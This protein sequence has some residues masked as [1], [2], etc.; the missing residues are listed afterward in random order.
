MK[1]P[2]ALRAAMTENNRYLRDNPDQLH[3]F[4]DAGRLIATRAAGAVGSKG[5]SF[6]YEY[7]LTIIVTDYPDDSA[8][9]MLPVIA[10]AADWQPELLANDDRQRDGIKFEAEIRTQTT[11]DVQIEIKLTESIDVRYVNGKPTFTY[12]AEPLLDEETRAFLEI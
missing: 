5:G 3:V 7:T 12:R 4:V 11:A 6:M 2:E 9:L 10:W 1:K 8:T